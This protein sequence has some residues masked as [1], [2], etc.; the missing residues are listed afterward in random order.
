MKQLLLN[1]FVTIG[2]IGI[3]TAQG[4]TTPD[5]NSTF[6]LD[7]LVAA[8]P[9]TISVSGTT[10]TLVEDLTISASDTFNISEDI[11][12]EIGE[13]IRIT[14]F[15]TFNV[16]ADN[17]VFTAIDTAAPYDGFRFEEF[18]DI[19][20]Q[21][22]TIQYGGGLRVLT[23]T[24]TIDNC[25][26][27][28]NVSGVSSSGVL[29]LSRGTPQ[30]T[31]N[32][33]TFNE[34]TAIG[35]GA[36]NQVSPYIFNN[37]IEGNN[38]ANSN[39]PQINLGPSLTDSPTEIIQNIIIGDRTLTSVGGVS[40]SDLL[41][42]AGVNAVIDNNTVTNNRY[43]ITIQS[44]NVS[45]FIRN[46]V[47]EDN[48]TQGN[49]NLGGSG[50]SL[51]ASAEGNEI[52]AS[53]N[54]IR[55]NLWGI[56]L[57]GESMINLGDNGGNIG[58]NVFSEN[59]NG[60]LT[61]ALYNNTDNALTAM[62]NCW[63]ETNATLTL[64]DA[65]AVISHQNDIPSLGLVTFDPVD[66]G[67]LDVDDMTSNE[68]RLYPNPTT[69]NLNLDHNTLF[70]QMNVYSIQGKLIMQESLHVGSNAL[71]LNLSAGMYLVELQGENARAT[72]KL[73]IK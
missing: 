34:T 27:T 68:V 60:G 29:G 19:S 16:D 36:S 62:H 15:G 65:E 30:I 53:G 41:G 73:V 25:L 1:F 69:G 28:N 43:G 32:T 6:T 5:T 67:F 49:P 37:Y 31:N 9:T 63:D 2:M 57:Q 24:F 13:D 8:S 12:I 58:Q 17:A 55:R 22:A 50:I 70:T 47:I 21:N 26:L 42:T 64:A 3:V 10:Y 59:G 39:R 18:S 7:D 52:I 14:V 4:Y 71:N 61:F 54:E 23:E 38:Q 40:V 35:S 48:D 44:N 46:N 72:K 11:T 20:I 56:T 45:A 51:V 66:C 33:I